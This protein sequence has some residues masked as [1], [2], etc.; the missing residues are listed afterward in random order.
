MDPIPGANVIP[1]GTGFVV[2]SYADLKTA[3]PAGKATKKS[4]GPPV[5][6]A[7]SKSSKNETKKRKKSRSGM[8]GPVH[9]SVTIAQ[10]WTF[11][12]EQMEEERA[13]QAVYTVENVETGP[14]QSLTKTQIQ[15]ETDLGDKPSAARRAFRPWEWS[16]KDCETVLVDALSHPPKRP[17]EN[18]ASPSTISE[19]THESVDVGFEQ[20]GSWDSKKIESGLTSRPNGS[21]ARGSV[22]DGKQKSPSRQVLGQNNLPTGG[23]ANE[24]LLLEHL[25]SRRC[26]G[27]DVDASRVASSNAPSN[28]CVASTQEKRTSRAHH[29]IVR[30]PAGGSTNSRRGKSDPPT[31]S[32]ADGQTTDEVTARELST[33]L[34][35]NVPRRRRSSRGNPSIKETEVTQMEE[36]PAGGASRT[37]LMR[38]KVDSRDARK[39]DNN[40][41]AHGLDGHPW[42]SK[43][44]DFCA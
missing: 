25:H 26:S 17:A 10:S 24:E 43:G 34:N 9:P 18:T 40:A 36:A 41:A 42:T 30:T 19:S 1:C 28:T 32:V 35:R 5:V 33:E 14:C 2:P 23:R 29:Q 27:N 13:R 31:C 16:A 22:K 11:R 7:R 6:S 44:L 12:G 20:G 4:T 8:S 15:K 21:I 38:S 39:A 37:K 3:K